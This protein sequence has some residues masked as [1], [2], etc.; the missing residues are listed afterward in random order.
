MDM[1]KDRVAS[2]GN[3][4]DDSVSIASLFLLEVASRLKKPILRVTDLQDA[5]NDVGIDNAPSSV[6][7]LMRLP[8]TMPYCVGI[9]KKVQ[10][11]GT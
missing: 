11:V 6:Q 1:S 4:A 3:A 5:I 2:D 8:L 7:M 10:A 9:T